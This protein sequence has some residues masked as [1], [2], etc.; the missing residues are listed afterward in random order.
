MVAD[1]LP[2][3]GAG[4][5]FICLIC[6]SA[7]ATRHFGQHDRRVRHTGIICT[8]WRKGGELQFLLPVG[9]EAFPKLIDLGGCEKLNS[10]IFDVVY[11]KIIRNNTDWD[12]ADPQMGTARCHHLESKNMKQIISLLELRWFC[13]VLWWICFII[14]IYF[15]FTVQK[16]LILVQLAF[17]WLCKWW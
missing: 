9:S 10:H 2:V 5:Y 16:T 15:L 6:P 7:I 12:S 3:Y 17:P 1:P 11:P 4:A 13:F 14:I 8:L